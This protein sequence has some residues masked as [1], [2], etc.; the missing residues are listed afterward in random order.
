MPAERP[1][2][3]TLTDSDREGHVQGSERQR[4]RLK[5]RTLDELTRHAPAGF[6]RSISRWSAGRVSLVHLHVLMLLVDDGR[7]PMWALAEALGVSRAS[8]TGIVDRMEQRGLVERQRDA[9]DRRVV[10]VALTDAGR[11]LIA[12]IATERRGRLAMLLDDLGD[13]EL[14]GLMRG[15]RALRKARER[16]LKRASTDAPPDVPDVPPRRQASE[17]SS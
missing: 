1:R 11:Q 13:E 10:N 17:P 15:S 9:D 7:L 2:A 16:M 5:A 14:R 3:K 4:E 6:M 8:A 12:G